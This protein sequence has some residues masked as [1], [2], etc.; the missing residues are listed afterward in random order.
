MGPIL[1]IS[2]KHSHR[3]HEAIDVAQS[4]GKRAMSPI[5]TSRHFAALR[6]LVAIEA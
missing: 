1:E 2:R 3:M 5:R 6:N 4:S